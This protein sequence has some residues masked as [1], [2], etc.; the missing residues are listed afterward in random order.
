MADFKLL[1]TGEQ[2]NAA[3][4]ELAAAVSE[5]HRAGVTW[6][7]P[8]ALPEADRKAIDLDTLASLS[9]IASMVLSI[10]SAAVAITDLADRIRKRKQA[11]TLVE[12]ATRLRVEKRVET[13][14]VTLESP[15]PLADMTPDAFL[16]LVPKEE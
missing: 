10:P 1:I 4:D 11:A 6:S 15:K 9:S 14:V 7:A 8:K 5:E 13:Y 16:E 12:T 3:A 2:A